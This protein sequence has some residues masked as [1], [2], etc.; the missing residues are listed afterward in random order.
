MVRRHVCPRLAFRVTM[1][2][3]TCVSDTLPDIY[4]FV[5]Q[6]VRKEREIVDHL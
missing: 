4:V 6:L 5:M 1:S 2:V 3:H